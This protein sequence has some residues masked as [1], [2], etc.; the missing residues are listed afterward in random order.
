MENYIKTLAKTMLKLKRFSMLSRSPFR[1]YHHIISSGFA[2]APPIRSSEVPYKVKYRL[3][4]TT[5]R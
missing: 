4:S 5:N 3:N 1:L 2:M